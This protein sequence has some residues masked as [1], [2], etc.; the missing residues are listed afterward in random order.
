MAKPGKVRSLDEAIRT[1]S[2]GLR[3]YA[4]RP[5]I[6]GY[7]PHEKQE[8]FHASAAK[9]K[10]FIGGN[11]SG[12]TVA[13]AVEGIRRS[14]G[15]DPFKKVKEPPTH[16]RIVSVD[17]LNGVEKIVRPEIARWVPPSELRG[18]SWH[19]A[20]SKELRTL[21]FDNGSTI[22]FMS[23]DQDLDKFA[24][25]SRD[26]IWFDEEPPK[27]IFTENRMR[28]IDVSGDAWITMTPVEG[29]TWVYDDIYIA[30]RVDPNIFVVEVDMTQNPYI[31][32]S[33]IE[34]YMT[35]LSADDRKA[36]IQGKFV[37][38]GGLIYKAF[39]PHNIVPP[40]NPPLDWMHV[41]GMDHGFN[42]PTA[43]LWA[44]LNPDGDMFVFDEHY[45]AGRIVGYHA[46]VVHGKN[47]DHGKYPDY[48]VGD[49]AIAQR[50]GLNGQ[51]VH[52]EYAEYGIPIMLGNNDVAGGI[53]RVARLIEGKVLPDGQRRPQLYI[54]SNC[55]QTLKE[56]SRYRWAV[57][58]TKQMQFD[59]N[60]KEEPQKKDDHAMDTIRYIV[61]S[62]P[63]VD[64]G[65]DIPRN[66]LPMDAPE[67]V[68]PYRRYDK[69]AITPR[70]SIVVDPNMGSDY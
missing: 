65:K 14:M 63:H 24:G 41:A 10:L 38:M 54:A 36:R 30:S 44:A 42:N 29:M 69:G 64:N 21:Y 8:L 2:Q 34:S 53:N 60:R 45:E 19:T 23:Y 16:G 13:G 49:P 43:W 57:W 25:T 58:Q 47:R 12:K 20:Y 51:S 62:R 22:E 39:G 26:W 68:N 48:Y 15:K 3:T 18:G 31:N 50:N 7:K 27:E 61:A 59:K 35:G 67:S 46:Q 6:Y 37:Q 70:S 28:L 66:V 17:F 40:F 33:E 9:V 55:V 56:I 5:N 1:I 52:S 32:Q 11:R 4:V